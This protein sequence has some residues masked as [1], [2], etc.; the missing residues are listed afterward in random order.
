V[1]RPE[2]A[3]T[4]IGRA[5]LSI[6][7][8]NALLSLMVVV[9]ATTAA[10]GAYHFPGPANGSGTVSGQVIA[11]PCGPIEPA[12]R[13]CIQGPGP[14]AQAPNC[15]PN[16]PNTPTCG[17]W[18]IPGVELVFTNGDTSLSAKTDSAGAYSIELPSR[19]WTVSTRGIMRI[20]SGPQTL[21]V[22]AGASI[23]ANYVVDTGIRA[24]A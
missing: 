23:V 21:A 14:A 5:A 15:L 6:Q 4:P 16:T 17:T 24:A 11:G 2:G 22:S 12:A 7:M 10:C 8:R 19:T 9:L 20:I 1:R 13:A 3:V 18:P